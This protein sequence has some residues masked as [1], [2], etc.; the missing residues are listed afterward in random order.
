MRQILLLFISVLVIVDSIL[1]QVIEKKWIES[2]DSIYGY[3][4]VIKPR[5]L[6]IQ[7]ALILLDGYSGNAADFLSETKIHNVA[8]AN[9]IINV[10]LDGI[11]RTYLYL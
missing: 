1:G 7:A 10:D 9:D 6:R 2:T 8:Y 11:K 3:Y 5:S 4:S